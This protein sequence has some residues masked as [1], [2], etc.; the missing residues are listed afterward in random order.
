MA[1]HLTSTKTPSKQ[2]TATPPSSSLAFSSGSIRSRRP[3]FNLPSNPFRSSPSSS[4]SKTEVQQQ[5]MATL[6]E[7]REKERERER[8]KLAGS[9]LGKKASAPASSGPMR[10]KK[11]GT[12]R[13]LM[14]RMRD[15]TFEFDSDGEGG[16]SL[17][18]GDDRRIDAGELTVILTPPEGS[19]SCYLFVSVLKVESDTKRADDLLFLIV[20]RE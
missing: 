15:S 11:Q 8:Q 18:M 20:H 19:L 17:Y 3:S 6:A 14:A 10:T 5:A 7:M 2:Q 9:L 1:S 4:A 13:S 12:V 16:G